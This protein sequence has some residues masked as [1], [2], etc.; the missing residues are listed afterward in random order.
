[1]CVFPIN[2][3]MYTEMDGINMGSPIGLN[4]VYILSS[5]E[6]QLSYFIV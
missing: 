5:L 4:L 1:M 2:D 3:S 6:N